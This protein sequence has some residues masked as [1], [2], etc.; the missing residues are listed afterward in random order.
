MASETRSGNRPRVSQG[1]DKRARYLLISAD[2]HAGPPLRQLREYFESKYWSAFDEHV[3]DT[4]EQIATVARARAESGPPKTR[5]QSNE[6]TTGWE[7]HESLQPGGN[8]G[9]YDANRRLRDMDADGIAAEV[10]FPDF[11]H[12]VSNP[13]P[14]GG[15]TNGH[16]VVNGLRTSELY[17]PEL[18]LAGCR[19]YNR[20]LADFCS[21]EHERR[22]GIAIV[23]FHDVEAVLEEIR[24]ACKTG[25]RGGILLPGMDPYLPGYNDPTYEPIWSLCEELQMPV[26]CHGGHEMGDYGPGPDA[27]VLW[28]TER[29]F[30]S[31]RP[32]W[33][34][35]WGGM[36]E[37]HPRLNLIFTEQDAWWVPSVLANLDTALEKASP[38]GR[39][40]RYSLDP[41]GYWDRQC[42]VG[43][44][45]IT[46][47]EA[48][49]R[50]EIGV[51]TIMWGS[52][53]P[54][55]EGSWPHT[56]ESVRYIFAS[57][58]EDELRPMLGENAAR[59]YHFDVEKLVPIA[60]RIGP[61]V[62]EVAQ[63]QPN[64]PADYVGKAFR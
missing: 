55:P 44:T 32:L 24:W 11:P 46:S 27:G 29:E 28:R 17:D 45:F 56:G 10:I 9:L 37:R 60:D 4:D 13:P 50:H 20:W 34:F 38:S 14:F 2:N 3:K 57:I 19:A 48:T 59:A 62:E 6:P 26:N 36:L 43:A 30:F 23:P 33:W 1:N 40:S 64:V 15:V 12:I 61:T 5:F 16:R 31:H 21:V 51:D 41:R 47:A 18:Q 35:I 22:A 54:H 49:A 52:D 8:P 58:P 39:P 25:L 53:Y 63:P 7:T 42:Y